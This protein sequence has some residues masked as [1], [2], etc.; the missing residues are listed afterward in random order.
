MQVSYLPGE[1]QGLIA[2]EVAAHGTLHARELRSCSQAWKQVVDCKI[3]TLTLDADSVP[4]ASSFWTRLPQLEGITITGY[5]DKPSTLGSQVLSTLTAN[6]K[7][8]KLMQGRRSEPSKYHVSQHPL[9]TVGNFGTT[10]L[11]WS[12]SLQHLELWNCALTISEGLMLNSPGFFNMFPCL[13][14][15]QLVC[16]VASKEEPVLAGLDLSGCSALRS[17]TCRACL[18]P[19]LDVTP[20]TSLTSLN[21]CDNELSSLN[22]FACAALH[23]LACSFNH[24]TALDLSAC[25]QI[26]TLKCKSNQLEFI[27]LPPETA[28]HTLKCSTDKDGLVV[29]G[30]SSVLHLNCRVSFLNT[31]SVE[32]KASLQSLHMKGFYSYVDEELADFRDLRSLTCEVGGDSAT[33]NFIGCSAVE[34]DCMCAE[35]STVQIEGRAAVTKLTLSGRAPL[36]NFVGFT[37]LEELRYDLDGEVQVL[38]LTMCKALRKVGHH[39]HLLASELRSLNVTGCSL[40]EE[41]D[42]VACQSM[43]ELDL[44]TCP[45][46]TAVSLVGSG[47]RILQFY[48]CPSLRRLHVQHS[49][50]LEVINSSG[51]EELARITC[52]DC[53]KLWKLYNSSND[54]LVRPVYDDSEP[55]WYNRSG[56]QTILLSHVECY[57]MFGC[58]VWQS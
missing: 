16:V 36:D 15:L 45:K 52:Y 30:L 6:L 50:S 41:L 53:P 55:D 28:L 7:A 10:L 21:C 1:V 46:L 38:D 22:L 34:V 32:M 5:L 11:R 9:M 23:T 51:C 2:R 27:N 48:N 44:S 24:L 17:L 12:L 49:M 19:S 3:E 33:L 40:L 20:C 35:D 54:K 14:S 37:A 39:T 47:V 29:F 43:S 42:I 13:L 31:L 8:V 25:P 56:E 58:R 18:L 26:L 4:Q 57:V